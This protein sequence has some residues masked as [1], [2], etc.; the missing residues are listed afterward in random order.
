MFIRHFIE[1]LFNPFFVIFLS[2]L[3]FVGLLF[4]KGDCRFVR[5]G[6]TVV[7]AGFFIA[8][9]GWL[10]RFLTHQ[11]ESQYPVVTKANPAIRWIVVLGGGQA[12]YKTSQDHNLLYSASIRRLM[13]A[14]RLYRQLPGAKL[15]LSGGEYGGKT[16]EALRLAALTSWFA[17]PQEDVILESGSMNTEEQARAIK[18]WVNN[19]PFYLVT[20][21]IHM[22]RAMAL[23]RTQGL[24]SI[25]A[26]TDFTYYWYDERWQKTYLPNPN[27]LV[28]LNIAWHEMLGR[29][30]A[31]LTGQST[32]F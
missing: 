2:L 16:A 20:S 29:A 7:M 10:P 22:P 8:S 14:V 24:K 21:A 31:W 15:L 32:L 6:L 25:A 28:Y 5:I 19:S 1:A 18:L 11:L 4:R 23:C 17:I 9:T 12:Q 13:E 30:W 27:N 3:V 26:P